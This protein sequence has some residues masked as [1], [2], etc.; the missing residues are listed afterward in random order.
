MK[1]KKR[2]KLPAIVTDRDGVLKKGKNKIRGVKKTLDK[3][4]TPLGK[5]FPNK[6]KGS[7]ARLPIYILTNGGDIPEKELIEV[8]NKKHGLEGNKKFHYS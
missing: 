5:L 1:T 6:F 8:I 4:R 7:K 2:L 3:I